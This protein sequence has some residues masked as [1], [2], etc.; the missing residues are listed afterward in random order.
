MR[1]YLAID[2]ESGRVTF[3]SE[4]DP[5]ND[6]EELAVIEDADELAES[7]D[8]D[9]PLCRDLMVDGSFTAIELEL[10]PVP[11]RRPKRR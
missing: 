5:T 6:L 7:A 1:I 2:H 9:C 4:R 8:E 10:A 3:Q 11:R